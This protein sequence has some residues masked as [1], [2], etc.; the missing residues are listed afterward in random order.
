[1][2]GSD[3]RV[4]LVFRS[5]KLSAIVDGQ[6]YIRVWRSTT[7]LRAFDSTGRL[8]CHQKNADCCIQ[9]FTRKHLLEIEGEN[10]G[11]VHHRTKSCMCHL[12]DEG[13]ESGDL[14]IYTRLALGGQS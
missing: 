11:V 14:T 5:G 3:E 12:A 13:R 1:V 8:D 7:N 4:V 2:K 10:V 9:R 6:A